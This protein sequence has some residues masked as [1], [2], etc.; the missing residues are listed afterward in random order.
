MARQFLG[1]NTADD[2]VVADIKLGMTLI[3]HFSAE[4]AFL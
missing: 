2:D 3:L 4:I 1:Q